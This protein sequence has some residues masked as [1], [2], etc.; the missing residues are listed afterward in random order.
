[1]L[2]HI[3]SLNTS[4]HRHLVDTMYRDR[5]R[6]F[7]DLLRWDLDHDGYHER[8][9]FDDEHADYIILKDSKTGEHR[10]SM[11]LLHTERP[12]LLSE[13]FA[14]LCERDVPTGPNIRE[15]TRFC[16]APRSSS[17]AR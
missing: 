2:Y 7:V 6:V 17:T 11:R 4:I 3:N 14:D 8:D 5:K 12:H 1:M 10:A 15:I 13:I 9:R 16:G